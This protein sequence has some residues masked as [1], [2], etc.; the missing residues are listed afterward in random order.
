MDLYQVSCLKLYTDNIL[1]TILFLN[2][3]HPTKDMEQIPSA[4]T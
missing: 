4:I 2:I 1:Y 3:V